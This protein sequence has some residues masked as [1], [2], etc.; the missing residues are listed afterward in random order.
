MTAMVDAFSQELVT[1]ITGLSKRQ[2]EYWD[3]TDANKPS[4]AE[5]T[6]WGRPRLYSFQVPSLL[7]A[8]NDAD[9]FLI[10]TLEALAGVVDCGYR[11][12]GGADINS[13]RTRHVFGQA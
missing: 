2:L 6:D 13:S 1:W 10:L 7:T 12:A 8:V 9:P 5:H 11:E 4:I 3:E